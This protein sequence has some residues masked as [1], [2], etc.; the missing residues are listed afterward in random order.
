MANEQCIDYRALLRQVARTPRMFVIFDDYHA[1]AGFVQ[2]I[3]SATGGSLLAGFDP[4]LAER[5]G[6]WPNITWAAQIIHHRIPAIARQERSPQS[7]SD[8]ESE[9]LITD[10]FDQLDR[11]LATRPHVGHIAF[12]AITS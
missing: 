7:L 1:I 10:L 4:W 2:G 9:I 12:D 8:T 11:F 6:G 5:Y 3:D